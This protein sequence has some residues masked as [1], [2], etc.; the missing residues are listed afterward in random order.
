VLYKHSQELTPKS[1]VLSTY[2]N[3]KRFTYKLQNNC[4]LQYIV[5]DILQSLEL[6]E[7]ADDVAD[8]QK[9]QIVKKAINL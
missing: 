6:V 4:V 3:I 8:N 1:S 5:N 2:L 7:S 9:S